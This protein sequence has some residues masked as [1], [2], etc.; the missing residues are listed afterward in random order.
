MSI[1]L[2]DN[3]KSKI[4]VYNVQKKNCANLFWSRSFKSRNLAPE[5]YLYTHSHVH[6]NN[7]YIHWSNSKNLDPT[8][9]FIRRELVIHITML[10]CMQVINIDFK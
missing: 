9:V 8:Q 1:L 6:K 10:S 2:Y 4:L 7:Q 5:I 3:V